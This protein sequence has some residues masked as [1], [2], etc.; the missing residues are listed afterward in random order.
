MSETQLF[1]T[2]EPGNTCIWHNYLFNRLCHI[3]NQYILN[4]GN[5]LHGDFRRGS[6]INLCMIWSPVWVWYSLL[7]KW[8]RRVNPWR[9]ITWVYEWTNKTSSFPA[10]A[11]ICTTIQLTWICSFLKQPGNDGVCMITMKS[12]VTS[13]VTVVAGGAVGILGVWVLCWL[14]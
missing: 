5:I 8:I 9:R 3:R 12:G 1:Q 4:W 7:P 10:L 11:S 2:T 6:V 13:S 14:L